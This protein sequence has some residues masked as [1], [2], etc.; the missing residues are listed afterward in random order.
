MSNF[1][2]EIDDATTA[3]ATIKLAVNLRGVTGYLHQ[4]IERL[5]QADI[6]P[7]FEGNVPGMY[8]HFR[9]T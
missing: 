2:S 3:N 9:L 4:H 7:P 8:T 1:F 5:V 6:G